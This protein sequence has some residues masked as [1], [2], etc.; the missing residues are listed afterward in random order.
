MRS[1]SLPV[2]L[3]LC[4]LVLACGFTARVGWAYIDVGSSVDQISAARAADTSSSQEIAQSDSSDIN[5]NADDGASSGSEAETT[6]ESTSAAQE[7][8]GDASDDQYE[9]ASDDLLSAGGS[10]DGPVPPMPGG[11]C[12]SEYP[13]NLVDGC[14][15]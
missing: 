14:Y 7:Q 5:V 13:I 6:N 3:A 10:D 4:C 1:L 2:K 12:P 9:D 11:G 15:K 8:Y